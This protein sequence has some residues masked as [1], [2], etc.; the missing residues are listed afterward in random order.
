[1]YC[2]FQQFDLKSAKYVYVKIFDNSDTLL[3]AISS[4]F[5]FEEYAFNFYTGT[6]A[7]DQCFQYLIDNGIAIIKYM[8]DPT[9]IIGGNA[10]TLGYKMKLT[11]KA[12]L[13]VL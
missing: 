5:I 10:T 4:M 2:E 8:I 11:P 6:I 13:N 7:S 3:C 9:Q 12:L 1:M